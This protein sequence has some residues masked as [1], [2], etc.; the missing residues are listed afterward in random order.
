MDV[1]EQLDK[2]VEI[3]N[4]YWQHEEEVNTEQ[5]EDVITEEEQKQKITTEKRTKPEEKRS[6]IKIIRRWTT[7][8]GIEEEIEFH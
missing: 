2:E 4:K 7:K 1:E 5:W 3:I 8:Y 6:Q